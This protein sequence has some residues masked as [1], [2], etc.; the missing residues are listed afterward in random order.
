[1]SRL[2][3]AMNI[4][5]TNHIGAWISCISGAT[6]IL[7]FYEVEFWH[8]FSGDPDPETIATTLRAMSIAAIWAETGVW[9]DPETATITG[10]PVYVSA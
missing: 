9:L 3:M 1:M 8:F 4:E 5:E 10:L 7:E 6:G 2:Y